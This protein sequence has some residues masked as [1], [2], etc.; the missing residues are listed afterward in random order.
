MASVEVYHKQCEE[1]HKN[2]L[3]VA[4]LVWKKFLGDT[5]PYNRKGS[6][7][8]TMLSEEEIKITAEALQYYL[9]HTR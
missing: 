4:K 5:V 7:L 6:K 1:F 8:F 3:N 2:R 9:R